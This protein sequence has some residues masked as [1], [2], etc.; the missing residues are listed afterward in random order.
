MFKFAVSVVLAVQFASAEMVFGEITDFV[1]AVDNG[2][3]DI[4]C[5]G[6]A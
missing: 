6:S 1:T 5:T 4:K 3:D 2:N